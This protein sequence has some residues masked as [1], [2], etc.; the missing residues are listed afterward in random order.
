MRVLQDGRRAGHRARRLARLLLPLDVL[1]GVHPLALHVAAVRG[2]ELALHG[3]GGRGGEVILSK[4]LDLEFSVFV[5]FVEIE[6]LVEKS[7]VLFGRLRLG[8]T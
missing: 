7:K 1:E 3:A 5:V 2:G 6:R 8:I 4:G